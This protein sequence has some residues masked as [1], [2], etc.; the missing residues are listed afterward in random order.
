MP[1]QRSERMRGK[2]EKPHEPE[3]AGSGGMRT[4]SEVLF[5]ELTHFSR[6]NVQK[7]GKLVSVVY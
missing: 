1:E 4:V 5:Q 3:T 2:R 6:L 7:L